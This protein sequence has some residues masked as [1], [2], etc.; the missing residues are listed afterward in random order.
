MSK[1][2]H[3]GFGAADLA[4]ALPQDRSFAEERIEARALYIG[5]PDGTPESVW[6]V[7]DF[8]DFNLERINAIKD[9]VAAARQV[10]WKQIHVLTTHNHGA[11]VE[12]NLPV[13]AEL[14]AQAVKEAQHTARPAVARGVQIQMPDG[15]NYHRRIY[16]PEFESTWT[17]FGGVDMGEHRSVAGFLENAID[18]M[19]KGTLVHVGWK[20][21]KRV[22]APEFQ[23]GD[24]NFFL[25]QFQDAQT[26]A[27]L[28]TI[29]RFAM[30]ATMRSSRDGSYYSSDY[31][32][33]V[34][35]QLESRFGGKSVFFNGPCGD[36]AACFPWPDK[37]TGVEKRYAV[38]MIEAGMNALATIPF[39]PLAAH[40]DMLK[41][42][43]PVRTEVL[44]NR[45]DFPMEMPSF[46]SLP[47]RKQWLERERL[48]TTLPF[49]QEKYRQGVP[50]EELRGF[51]DIEL[52]LLRLNQWKLLAFPGETF[53]TTG[54]A[55]CK[56]LPEENL[57]T[58]TEH[59]RTAMYLAPGEE[60][61]DGGYESICSVTAPPAEEIMR[62]AAIEFAKRG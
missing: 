30:H 37:A 22:N 50:P 18:C 17:C 24:P 35:Q 52:G 58:L 31:P 11:D 4:S 60:F 36:L 41:V 43:L 27:P 26:D 13:L 62:E 34:R 6:V 57:V 49:L 39:E 21:S 28:G 25:M 14:A 61:R 56:A 19:R 44:A 23:P 16:I 32:W 55:V 42:P 12:V 7:L 2:F 3:I 10:P 5:C 20:P 45:V 53:W 54:E 46:E 33:H 40:S 38:Q 9:A 1:A 47:K 15:I 59:G 51:I 8:M 48:N 29:S